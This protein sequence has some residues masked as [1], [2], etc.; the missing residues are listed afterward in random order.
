MKL[1]PQITNGSVLC[2]PFVLAISALSF[3][4][5]EKK[6]VGAQEI[7]KRGGDRDIELHTS[8]HRGDDYSMIISMIMTTLIKAMMMT[9][10]NLLSLEPL[11]QS[12]STARPTG[13]LAELESRISTAFVQMPVVMVL[14]PLKL[15]Y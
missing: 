1:N 3:D 5:L 10:M 9:M 11:Y 4:S 8:N 14:L 2:L 12:P 15:P 6:N 13:F 7:A